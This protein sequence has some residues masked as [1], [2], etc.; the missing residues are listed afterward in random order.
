LLCPFGLWTSTAK[1][2]EVAAQSA[3]RLGGFPKVVDITAIN[4]L[5]ANSSLSL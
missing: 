2:L 3:E 4:S 1:E 5:M